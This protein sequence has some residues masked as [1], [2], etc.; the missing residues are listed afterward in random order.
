[1]IVTTGSVLPEKTVTPQDFIMLVTTGS[2]L[3][4]KAVTP[5]TYNASYYRLGVTR[6]DSN[7]TDFIM[8]V[9]TGSV[10]PEKTVNTTDKICRNPD[11]SK[12]EAA[13]MMISRSGDILKILICIYQNFD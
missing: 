4:E 12:M 7:T 6:K 2:V 13:I 11:F 1:M 5:T 9:T 8:L 3:P 10:L